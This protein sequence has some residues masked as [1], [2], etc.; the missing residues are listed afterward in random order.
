MSTTSRRA[1]HSSHPSQHHL[2][3]AT[4]LVSALS[5]GAALAADDK[6]F[7]VQGLA[8]AL[9]GQTLEEAARALGQALVAEKPPATPEACHFR[10]A[11]GQPGVRYAVQQGRIVRSETRDARYA[12]ASGV[13]VGDALAKAEKAY[14]KRLVV[15][16]HP[17]FD[18][19]RMLAVYAG[20]RQHALV[21][22]TNDR[23]Q[24]ITLRGGRVPQVLALEGCS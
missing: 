20:D 14:G 3:A 7:T 11:A 9:A 24:I 1:S 12:T 10:S 8:P 17:Y 13:R 19:G 22:E 5:C 16:P 6:R 18:K 2:A 21:M 4:L 23:G 15:K